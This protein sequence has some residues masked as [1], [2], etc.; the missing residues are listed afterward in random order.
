MASSFKTVVKGGD[1]I[2]EVKKSRFIAAVRPVSSEQDALSFLNSE[3]KKYYDAKHHCSAYIL[4][5]S[6]GIPD[7]VHAADD[8]EPSGTAG[9]PI[10]EVI[11][12]ACL[13]NVICVVTRYFGG[14]LLGTGGLVRAYTD[15]AK[16]AVS[17]SDIVYMH[18]MTE[19]GIIF[20]Y[21]LSGKI[22]YI[23]NERKI[24][25]AAT[26][27]SEKVYIKC[28]VMENAA[29]QLISELTDA[30]SGNI[31]FRRSEA[32]YRQSQDKI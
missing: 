32:V 26:E 3:Q 11:S 6:E 20:D 25:I 4:C 16:E 9:K 1:A 24:E 30:A 15:A 10:L 27:Y 18:R 23:L 17:A 28:F 13:K 5:G 14:T 12:G 19:L 29:G 2:I 22:Q 7:I 31:R 8:G 21:P